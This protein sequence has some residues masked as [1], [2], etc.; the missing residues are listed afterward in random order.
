MRGLI[1]SGALV[2][3]ATSCGGDCTVPP[4]PEA[5]AIQLSVTTGNGAAVNGLTVKV[6]GPD[7]DVSCQQFGPTS[8]VVAGH[9][10]NYQLA[11]SAPGFQSVQKTV[12]VSSTGHYGC[13][14]CE[15][16]ST[17]SVTVTLAPTA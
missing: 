14:T 2:A 11:I 15:I 6:T 4:C 13:D 8:C 9:R 7:G 3:A 16:V 10:G 12:Q 1:W 17:Q 5:F